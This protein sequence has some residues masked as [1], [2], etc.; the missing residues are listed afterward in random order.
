MSPVIL[1]PLTLSALLDGLGPD[2]VR[3]RLCR[4][5]A[6][7]WTLF[8]P[9]RASSATRP[10]PAPWCEDLLDAGWIVPCQSRM[11]GAV[12]YE[13]AP[14]DVPDQGA[15]VAA[16]APDRPPVQTASARRPS[17]PHRAGGPP[18]VPSRADR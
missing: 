11:C 13:A 5:A 15:V 18:T 8:D 6:G 16:P 12:D 7:F 10:V 9:A 3:Y 1:G 14:D 17:D 2:G 4:S